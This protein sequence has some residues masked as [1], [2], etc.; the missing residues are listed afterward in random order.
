MGFTY[1]LLIAVPM[2]FA[3][4]ALNCSPFCQLAFTGI[5]QISLRERHS[6]GHHG[7]VILGV[8]NTVPTS[9]NV[10]PGANVKPHRNVPP[11]WAVH[12]P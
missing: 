9:D 11:V 4:V 12:T 7:K 1:A 8:I 10:T 2:S 5:N 6:G 3:S